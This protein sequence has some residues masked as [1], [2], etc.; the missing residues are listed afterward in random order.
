M[1]K[2]LVVVAAAGATLAAGCQPEPRYPGALQGVVELDERAAALEVGGQLTALT[3][4]E[5]DAVE[6]GAVI[7]NVD[8]A[9]QR[10]LHQARVFDAEAAKAQ[11]DLLEAGPRGEEI[12]AMRARLDAARASEKQLAKLLERHRGLSGSVGASPESVVEEIDARHKAAIAQ[13]RAVE[14]ELRALREGS[15]SQEVAAAAARLSAATAAA[16]LEAE[17]LERYKL[18]APIAGEVVAV[19]VERGEIAS[20]GAP[21]VTIADPR[22]PYADVYVPQADIAAVKTGGAATVH[23]DALDEPLRGEVEYIERRTEFTPRFVFSEAERPNLVIRV[24]VR[25]DDPDEKLRP[26]LPAF[27]YFREQP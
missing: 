10:K 24:R 26:G 22:H 11:L 14:Q 12:R 17:R 4:D 9:V 3:V 8:D 15:R 13:R 27:V 7:G 18:R 23:V 25:I 19:H 16:E 21:V 5:G 1:I 2:N 6:A 20:P